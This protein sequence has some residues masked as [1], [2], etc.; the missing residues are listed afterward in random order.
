MSKWRWLVYLGRHTQA[1]IFAGLLGTKQRMSAYM[2]ST[3]AFL[4]DRSVYGLSI[5]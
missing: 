2:W 4:R 3:K 1:I 5:L